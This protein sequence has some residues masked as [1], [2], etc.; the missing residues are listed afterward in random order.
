[1]SL[2]DTSGGLPTHKISTALFGIF[3]PLGFA[4]AHAIYSYGSKS[5]YDE[6]INNLARNDAGYMFLSV[7]LFVQCNSLMFVIS[8]NKRYQ[9][10]LPRPDQSLSVVVDDFKNPKETKE[11]YVIYEYKG[12]AGEFNRSVR[13]IANYQEYLPLLV[14]TALCAG[15]V[16][17]FPTFVLTLAQVFFRIIYQINYTRAAGGR[18]LGFAISQFALTMVESLT[19]HA[20][21]KSLGWF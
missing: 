12:L 9:L 20:A 7:W 11:G 8:Q 15:Q 21:V 14:G 4:C 6:R 10:G 18:Q 1:M 13:A 17:P 5:I 2:R 3:K 19:L 16:Y